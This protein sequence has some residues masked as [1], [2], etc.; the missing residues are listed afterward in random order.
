MNALDFARGPGLHWA[1]ALLVFGFFWRGANFIFRRGDRDLY[2]MRKPLH[3]PSARWQLDSYAMHAGLAVVILA[4]APHILLIR[5]LTGLGWPG[6]PIAVVLFAGAVTIMAMIA[7]LVHRIFEHEPSAFSAFDDYFSWTI[8]FVAVATGM[9]CYPH[10]GGSAI[11]AP[12]RLLLTAHLLSVELLMVWLPFGKLG[13]VAMMPLA[14]AA[15]V[16]LRLFRGT[17]GYARE[18]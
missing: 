11:I 6:L 14:R 2:W 18:S 3:V 17:R 9:L 8:V 5:E 1:L 4:F 12:Y 15:A 13:H 10:V 16:L 7:V